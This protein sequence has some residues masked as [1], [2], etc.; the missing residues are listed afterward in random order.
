VREIKKEMLK[1]L[2]NKFPGADHLLK[3]GIGGIEEFAFAGK[4]HHIYILPLLE[5]DDV[6]CQKILDDY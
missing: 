6:S 4:L 3:L 1:N 2:L 5:Q